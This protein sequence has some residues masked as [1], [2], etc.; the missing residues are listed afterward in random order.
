MLHLQKEVGR[1]YSFEARAGRRGIRWRGDTIPQTGGALTAV[2]DAMLAALALAQTR[3]VCG[4]MAG[5]SDGELAVAG[6]CDD[7]PFRVSFW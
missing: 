1:G 7:G 3:Q 2:T 5:K 6:S 4:E